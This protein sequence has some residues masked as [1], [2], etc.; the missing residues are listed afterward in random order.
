MK[1]RCVVGLLEAWEVSPESSS[2][3]CVFKWRCR[4]GRGVL[5]VAD[6]PCQ[7]C[8]AELMRYASANGFVLAKGAP[9][10]DREVEAL[11]RRCTSFEGSGTD[12]QSALLQS[13][14]HGQ[15]LCLPG[16]VVKGAAVLPNDSAGENGQRG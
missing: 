1:V 2:C 4:P 15:D 11:R 9:D 14:A 16:V 8:H 6:G 10:N 13:G 5:Y 12:G 3:G 7:A